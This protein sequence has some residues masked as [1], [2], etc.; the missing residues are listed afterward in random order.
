MKKKMKNRYKVLLIIVSI[1]I[2]GLGILGVI[3]SKTPKDKANEPIKVLD[4]IDNFPYKLKE[5]DSKLKKELFYELEKIL[6]EDEVDDQK[7]AQVLAKLFIVDTFSLETKL[8]KYDIGGLDFVLDSEKEKLKN[9][10]SDTLYDNLENNFDGKREQKLPLVSE[11][12]ISECTESKFLFDN[13]E[14]LS[15]DIVLNWTYKKDLGYDTSALV[16]VVK[17]DDLMYI[18]SYSS[19]N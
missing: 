3:H 2:I 9:I 19:N 10:L 8:N 11:I 16:K 1:L 18:V 17:V 7:Y 13:K 5:N 12:E 15:Y 4:V 6:K 14:L